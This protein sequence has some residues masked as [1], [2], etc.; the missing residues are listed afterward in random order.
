MLVVEIFFSLGLMN[1]RSSSVQTALLYL[2]L[3][4]SSVNRLGSGFRKP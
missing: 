3:V 2:T 4:G 1:K